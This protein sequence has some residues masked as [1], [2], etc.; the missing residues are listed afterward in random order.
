MEAREENKIKGHEKGRIEQNKE[1]ARSMKALGLSPEVIR[2]VTGL[3]LEE[4]E[5]I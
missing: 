5:Q 4:I 3:S 2:Q 1:N